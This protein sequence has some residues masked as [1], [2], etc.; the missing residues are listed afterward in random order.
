AEDPRDHLVVPVARLQPEHEELLERVAPHQRRGRGGGGSHAADASAGARR[1]A[2][3]GNGTHADVRRLLGI[4]AGG[5]RS[6]TPAC[7]S[8]SS[9]RSVK[10]RSPSPAAPPPPT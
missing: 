7:R 9:T 3:H 1:E 10:S 5:S 6:A 8:I 4:H 2:M